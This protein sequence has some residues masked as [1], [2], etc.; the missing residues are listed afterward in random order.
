V[1][2]TCRDPRAKRRDSRSGELAGSAELLLAR[3]LLIGG[4]KL[5]GIGYLQLSC[6][7]VVGCAERVDVPLLIR[8]TAALLDVRTNQIALQAARCRAKGWFF[9]A[10]EVLPMLQP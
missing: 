5:I 8:A 6:V 9:L 2:V 4:H 10:A 1:P 3:L 7:L